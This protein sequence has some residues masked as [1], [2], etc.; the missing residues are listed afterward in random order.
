MVNPFKPFLIAG[1]R[2]QRSSSDTS[3]PSPLPR[4]RRSSNLSREADLETAAVE[5][6]EVPIEDDSEDSEQEERL[7]MPIRRPLLEE[8]MI[9]FRRLS[10]RSPPVPPTLQ[11]RRPN[12]AT[13]TSSP[14]T[15]I[16]PRNIN[17]A[18]IRNTAT[19]P[20]SSGP[21]PLTALSP[22]AIPGLSAFA[23]T[24]SPPHF[25]QLTHPGPSPAAPPYL[26][27]TAAIIKDLP[28]ATP[29][30]G[31]PSSLKERLILLQHGQLNF[32]DPSSQT[33]TAN[34]DDSN[35]PGKLSSNQRNKSISLENTRYALS[36]EAHNMI[37][38]LSNGPPGSI[39]RPSSPSPPS[40]PSG[41][42]R[43]ERTTRTM[44]KQVIFRDLELEAKQQPGIFSP[45]I[46]RPD[47]RSDYFSVP[48][49]SSLT[50]NEM[51]N[52]P[53]L[54]TL[55]QLN[56]LELRRI[57][58]ELSN[59]KKF[60]DPVADALQRLAERKGSAS[61]I[62]SASNPSKL[63][64]KLSLSSSW[65]RRLSPERRD[66]SPEVSMRKNS[67]PSK[68]RETLSDSLHTEA[69]QD[70]QDDGVGVFDGERES[71]LREATRQL[72]FSWP[73]RP[74]EAP[75]SEAGEDQCNEDPETTGSASGTAS[76]SVG[77]RSVSPTEV[78]SISPSLRKSLG[79][80]LKQTWG[81]ALALAGLK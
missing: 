45:M 18:P 20:R 36:P 50:G 71:K 54:N 41:W 8:P 22:R 59:V 53:F 64:S 66:S 17:T 19:S 76:E 23:N 38:R 40:M 34:S 46:A 80:G 16:S 11:L 42:T 52:D 47:S 43:S 73:E 48:I 30:V 72:W 65:M 2:F 57:N 55:P 10:E 6:D 9:P 14:I 44:Q 37:R 3:N 1:P 60:S 69:Q 39:R 25:A 51:N 33:E 7:E 74:G 15:N 26:T 49:T 77:G 63:D 21:V 70:T 13:V 75:E 58:K 4:A 29:T 31:S 12:L 78:R 35:S 28:Y 62:L 24:T 68:L 32:E 79:S 81:S 67:L 61:P 27:T 56:S 5:V